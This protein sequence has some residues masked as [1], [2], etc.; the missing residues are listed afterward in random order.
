MLG[1]SQTGENRRSPDR[2]EAG[3]Q[4]TSHE[5][6]D[7][8]LS[9]RLAWSREPNSYREQ[10]RFAFIE[11]GSREGVTPNGQENRLWAGGLSGPRRQL[12]HRQ[13]V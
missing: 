4:V 8:I 13:I 10:S 2:V 6:V 3:L 1:Y 5:K 7:T 12:H 11:L 9:R